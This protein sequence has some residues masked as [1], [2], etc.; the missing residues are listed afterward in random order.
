MNL[1]DQAYDQK[2]VF[3]PR[4]AASLPLLGALTGGVVVGLSVLLTEGILKRL[5]VNLDDLGKREYALTGTWDEP[6]FEETT[7]IRTLDSEPQK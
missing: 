3:V 6:L 5:G 1:V 7:V 4:V 2:I